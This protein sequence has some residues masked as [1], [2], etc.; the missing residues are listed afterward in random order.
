MVTDIDWEVRFNADVNDYYTFNEAE[1]DDS[2]KATA[3]LC[4]ENSADA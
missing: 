4:D 2:D 1:I 3:L